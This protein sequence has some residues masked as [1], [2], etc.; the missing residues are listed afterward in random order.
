MQSFSIDGVVPVIPT[1][2]EADEQVDWDALCRL[3]DF[4]CV[5]GASA[6]CLPAYASEFYK[7]TGEERQR[8]I[9]EAVDQ[10]AGRI[11]VI[12]QVNAASAR[13]A[14]ET[15]HQIATLG[16][17]AVGITVPRLFA[18]GEAAVE[19]YLD[20]VL[21]ASSLPA[22]IQ[23]FNPGGPTVSTALI[24]R[25]NQRFPHFRYVKLEEAMMGLRVGEILQATEG[26]VG[27]LEGW[28]GMYMI[29]LHAAGIC[30]VVPGLAVSDLLGLVW[31]HLKSG[32][33]T[34][35]YRIFQSVLPQ[36]VFSLQNIEF[37]HHAEKRLLMARG[38]LGSANVRQLTLQPSPNDDV[39]IEFLNQRVLE[40]LE[41][42]NLPRIPVETELR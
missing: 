21:S 31:R 42:L 26:R 6:L 40:A 5:S 13:A 24:A 18:T 2:F 12:G 15:V 3:I 8:T 32:A 30:G 4:A 39:H 10:A 16:A 17:D 27:V 37:F 23:D 25:L 41:A 36:I 29:E 35:A 33:R 22:I 19:G 9:S 20:T 7:L 34:E 1:P 11:P 38:L 14:A 28:G